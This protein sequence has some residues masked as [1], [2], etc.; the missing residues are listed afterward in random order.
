MI[1]KKPT[2]IDYDSKDIRVESDLRCHLGCPWLSA[3]YMLE[4][5]KSCEHPGPALFRTAGLG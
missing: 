1:K 2:Q 5:A 3:M 4:L